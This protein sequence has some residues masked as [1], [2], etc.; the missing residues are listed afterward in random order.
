MMQHALFLLYWLGLFVYADPAQ[1]APP[2]P[3]PTQTVQAGQ[4][5]DIVIG[6]DNMPENYPATLIGMGSAGVTIKQAQIVQQQVIFTFG[7][8]ETRHAGRI[9]TQLRV[10]DKTWALPIE[11]TPLPEVS[12]ILPV[13]VPR[14]IV[15][16]GADSSVLTV[17]ATDPLGNP[18]AADT[19]LQVWAHYPN[20]A[21]ATAPIEIRTRHL[22]AWL[23]L[24]SQQHAGPLRIGV[25]AS[26]PQGMAYGPEQI[27]R[28]VPNTGQ[29]FRLLPPAQSLLA[30]GYSLV[31]LVSE[32]VFDTYG[33]GLLDGTSG[34]ALVT[35]ADDTRRII[36]L[37]VREGRVKFNLQ[38]P[39]AAG[40][41]RVQVFVA[42]AKS[43][44][45]RLNFAPALAMASFSITP[46]LS[47][48]QLYVRLSIG[49]LLSYLGQF[50]PDGTPVRVVV[51]HPD[52]TTT[53]HTAIA[54]RGEA[55]LSLRSSTLA[56]GNYQ[57]KAKLGGR[58]A[59]ASFIV[60]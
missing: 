44:V 56:P 49:P 10:G 7:P 16:G 41:I 43:E 19:A 52:G 28:I 59:E 13:A 48:N 12:E 22:L 50:V 53:Q 3:L 34:H 37:Q 4:A 25:Q 31:E 32:P 14:S 9:S 2:A 21:P 40:E 1:V 38:T 18:L 46:R 27:V 23:R 24:P 54:E 58:E 51:A 57:F 30:D 60:P 39:A 35:D 47:S 33:N 15:A 26:N 20:V 55:M 5:I 6:F 11:I 36:P 42:D 8:A 17:L 29:A 45:L